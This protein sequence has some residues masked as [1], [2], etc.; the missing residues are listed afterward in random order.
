MEE[1]EHNPAAPASPPPP[2]P[3]PVNPL[4][5]RIQMPGETFALPSGGV[6]YTHGE[7]DD[8]VVNAEVR[9]H[10]IDRKSVV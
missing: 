1:T 3:K 5:S 4:L 8:S 6:F 2:P 9:V 10:P 7:L